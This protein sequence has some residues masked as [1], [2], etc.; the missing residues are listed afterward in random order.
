MSGHLQSMGRKAEG[1][2]FTATAV[3]T[4]SH[5]PASAVARPQPGGLPRLLALRGL[6]ADTLLIVAYIVLSRAFIGDEARLGIKIGPLP[7]FVTDAS[8][9]VLIVINLH[10]RGGRLLQWFFGGGGAGQIGRAVWLL[11]LMTVVYFAL[12][13][14]HYRLLAMR[15]LAIFGY[16]IFFPLTYFGLTQGV[17]AAKLVRYFI[18]ATCLG[19]ALFEF[20]SLSGAKLFDLAQSGMRACRGRA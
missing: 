12:G 6:P 9:L 16:S 3:H 5:R 18:Y 14:P 7:L 17:Q 10:K 8:L 19:A 11:F 13:F 1:M 4:V 20:Q 15:D 2:R